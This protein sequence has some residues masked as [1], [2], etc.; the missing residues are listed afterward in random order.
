M[1]H[2]RIKRHKAAI[3]R[4]D[5]SRP[6]KCLWRDRM[7]APERTVFDY[8]CG[9][10]D[11]LVALGEEGIDCEGFDPVF[12]PDVEPQ[13]ADIVNLGYV[14]N[15]IENLNERRQTLCKAWSLANRLL[16][17]AARVVMGETSGREVVYG[18]GLVTSI[19]TFQKYYT[20]A[21]LR[22]YIE[23]ATGE[24]ALPAAPGV[25]YVF[26]DEKL[27][28]Q[29]LSDRVRRS[30]AAPRKRI[31]EVRFE[32]NR[33]ILE[34]LIETVLSLGRLPAEDEFALAAEV[35]EVFG[36]LKRAFALVKKVTGEED[37]DSIHT[38]RVEDLT[39]YI[40]LSKF[41]KRPKMAQLPKRTQR[42]IKAFFGSYKNA[43]E[44]A[45][46]LLF[47]AGDA[48]N[49]D[50]ACRESQIGRL[51]SNALWLHRDAVPL[52]CPILRIY[53]GCAQAYVGSMDDMN[54][55]KLHRFSGKLSYLSCP[56]FDRDAHPAV[57]STVK[58]SLRTLKLDY[59]DHAKSENPLLLDQKEKM[60]GADHPLRAKFERLTKQEFKR[61]LMERSWDIRS[62]RQWSEQLAAFGCELR[63]HRLARVAARGEQTP[64]LN[65]L[66]IRSKRF[67]VGKEIGGNVYVHRDYED[68][69]GERVQTAKKCIP[70][71]F[72]YTVVKLNIKT[73][74]LT[75]V[76]SPDF[77]TADEPVVGRHILV[78]ADGTTQDRKQLDDPYIYHHKWLMVEDTYHG[79]DVAASRHR[80][81]HWMSLSNVDTARIGRKSYWD[82]HVVPRIR[83]G[84]STPEVS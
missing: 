36:S 44:T 15:V 20:Q 84:D 46:A 33:E 51:T 45:D 66:P 58:L 68:V 70:E 42:D 69:L 12:R 14:I 4:Y 10:G 13:Q 40:A 7:I 37:W 74:A 54:I 73:E 21:E 6:V 48:D 17:V 5:Y 24:E 64:Q 75:F 35:V 29:F 3:K 52:L 72:E 82:A 83:A 81:L 18:D 26:R 77:D 60:V 43:C 49:I 76:S 31:A 32:E 57:T 78:R 19:G 79:F 9:H 80:S 41:G 59:F 50:Q 53:E 47:Q 55:V 63:G 61:G 27:K 16:C 67:G 28:S 1:D 38:A 56:N 65:G 71:G 23:D 22:E 34:P 62:R 2:A 30:I 25:F 8:G 11:D 39:V